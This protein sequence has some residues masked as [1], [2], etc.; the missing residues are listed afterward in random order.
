MYMKKVN[1]SYLRVQLKS[2]LAYVAK[3]EEVIVQK[4]N[5]DVAKLSP[6]KAKV[7]NKTKIGCGIGSVRKF[8]DPHAS[9]IPEENWEMHS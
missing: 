8:K 9:F 3:G 2:L 5:L 4:R 1:I 6:V 7:A